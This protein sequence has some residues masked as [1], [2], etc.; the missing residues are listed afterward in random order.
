MKLFVYGICLISFFLSSC[1]AE[2]APLTY[3]YSHVLGSVGVHAIHYVKDHSL[4]KVKALVEETGEIIEMSL[5]SDNPTPFYILYQPVHFFNYPSS[6]EINVIQKR[7]HVAIEKELAYP[8]KASL[9]Q[10]IEIE[11]LKNE[12]E[13]ITGPCILFGRSMGASTIINYMAKYKP[14]N[15]KAI[16]LESPFDTVERVVHRRIGFLDWFGLGTLYLKYRHPAYNGAGVKPVNVAHLIDP[17]IPILF[18]HS[19]KDS[20]VPVECSR[21][22]YRVIKASG[23]EQ[24]HLFELREAKHNNAGISADA[25]DY[26]KVVHAFYKKYGLPCD[27]GLALEGMPLL[28]LT[29][30]N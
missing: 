19:K 10:H 15:V 17:H 24:V 25:D 16:V 27:E 14:T 23:N 4:D 21:T 11:T 20:F 30:P 7:S 1:V 9:A 3:V 5:K 8:E 2:N 22:L 12:M 6:R 13:K 28:A 26:Q 29:R 18:I